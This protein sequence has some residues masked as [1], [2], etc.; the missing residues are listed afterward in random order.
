MSNALR[1]QKRNWVKNTYGGKN[2]GPIWREMMSERKKKAKE[3]V[4]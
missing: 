4:K 2:V 1:K 3:E